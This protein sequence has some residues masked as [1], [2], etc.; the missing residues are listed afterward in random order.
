MAKCQGM[1]ALTCAG[2]LALACAAE[3]FTI[4]DWTVGG[5]NVPLSIAY[6]GR[7]LTREVATGWW[8]PH[9]A[10]S[11]M[12]GAKTSI[13]R[14]GDVVRL[15]RAND[16]V[17]FDLA[18]ACSAKTARVTLAADFRKGAGPF[19]YG[20]TIPLKT[21][22]TAA[23]VPIMR[24]DGQSV[25]IYADEAFPA[26]SARQVRFDVPEA[27]Y[28]LS[29]R[30]GDGGFMMQDRRTSDGSGDA[31]YILAK[32][33]DAP[34]RLSFVH[35]WTVEDDFDAATRA[36]RE[37]SCSRPMDSKA[38]VAFDNPG[39]ESAGGG[40]GLPKNARFDDAVAHTGRRSLYMS[41]TGAAGDGVYATRQ[42][43]VVGGALYRLGAFV[44]TEDVK[45]VNV[46]GKSSVGA[47]VIVEWCDKSGRW[48]QAGEYATGRYGTSDW[49]RQRTGW[50]VAPVDAGFATVF[51]TLRGTGRAWFDDVVFERR[52]VAFD[53]VEPVD[54]ARLASNT[55]RF[56]WRMRRGVRRYDV[57]LSRDAAFLAGQVKKHSA[58]GIPSFQLEEPLDEGR[59]F[60][61]IGANGV[62]D[63]VPQSFD[64]AVPKDRDTLPPQV[65]T[66][67]ARVTASDAAFIVRV[68]DAGVR[69]PEVSFLGVKGVCQTTEPGGVHVY[70]FSAPAAGW[71][72]GLTDGAVV[73]VDES[74]NCATQGV[75]FLNAPRP[76]NCTKIDVE[77]RFTVAGRPFFPLGIYE[78][79]EKEMP[80]VRAAGFDVV[81]TYR[82]EGSTNDVACAG[83][84]DACW[85][86]D[87]LRAFIGFDRRSLVAGDFA[88]LAR[89]VAALA[90]H[91]G[92]F[93]WYL[94]DEPEIAGQF[95]SPDLLT[96]YADLIR[97]LDP[98]H[99]VV[100]T[101][102]NKTMNEY[103]RTWD[104]HW[105]QAYGDP[106][107]VVRTLDEQRGYLKGGWESPIT[108]L[109][110]S[111]DGE[112]GK[113]WRAGATP[114]PSK[115]A[116]DYNYLRAC[117]MLAL[118]ERCNGVW[119][120][121]YAPNTR[122][123]FTVAQ[124]PRG[125]A[126]LK[127]VLAEIRELRPLV[128][129]EG[130]VLTGRAGA[131]KTPVCWW[132]KTVAGETTLVAV[133]TANAPVEVAVAVP[134]LAPAKLAFDARETKVRKL[135][136]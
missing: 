54:G 46:D 103:R 23:G 53:K 77:G 72:K 4:G 40:W 131:A 71:P 45:D 37:R 97:A 66:R 127:R 15:T 27:A 14:D 90:S 69:R 10:A 56:E 55:P 52:I 51:L 83:Y 82:W 60:W 130:A 44:R 21:F 28:S 75:W 104:T 11:Q 26:R 129:A 68:K 39:F 57:E 18:V 48:M 89:R 110:N 38:N 41:V 106:A 1:I 63:D 62:S 22:A 132:A 64:V 19:E 47:G 42:I 13:R 24:L 8:T 87:G 36:R 126:D 91:P 43:P 25:P 120:W 59:W 74:G 134:G 33:V 9:Y 111:N 99:V 58:G 133:N 112:L 16:R 2:V 12:G 114:D 78:V 119:W 31:R 17:V 135:A 113:L 67:G 98:Y 115:Y 32:A 85:R 61:R 117:A 124:T 94:F 122:E 101:T 108:L 81:H 76:A 20:F 102:W 5:G 107:G 93:C 35:E 49:K 136:R 70:L 86:T 125:W 118:P 79:A 50:I 30:C 88:P 123:Y 92:L 100:M 105:T 6:R 73:A 96:A 29:A 80:V 3:T 116:K 95:V 109:V 128:E 84:L 65:L 121:W 34:S 7:T